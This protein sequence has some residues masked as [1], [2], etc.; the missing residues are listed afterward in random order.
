[1][2]TYS[3]YVFIVFHTHTHT[4]T[5][6]HARTHA[7]TQRTPRP[8]TNTYM[9]WI[10]I[11]CHIKDIYLSISH[12]RGAVI[13][14][15]TLK[16]THTHTHT[17]HSNTHFR[18]SRMWMDGNSAEQICCRNKLIVCILRSECNELLDWCDDPVYFITAHVLFSSLMRLIRK[19]KFSPNVW[20]TLCLTWPHPSVMPARS[21]GMFH[22][23][24]KLVIRE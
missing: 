8:P 5:R 13:A 15:H 17:T 14:A 3:I 11:Y 18:M 12:I 7:R 9:A 21:V 23:C 16:H 1:M 10:D 4:H 2:S 24:F 19:E 20:G 22:K 6:T